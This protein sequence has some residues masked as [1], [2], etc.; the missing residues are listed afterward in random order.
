MEEK[1]LK[2]TSNERKIVAQD[3]VAQPIDD[4]LT[5][6]LTTLAFDIILEFKK[7]GSIT[8]S[9]LFDKLEKHPTTPAQLEEIYKEI[10]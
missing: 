8:T 10:N 4:V 6:E 9:Q 3:V 1:D 5:P 7:S 2:T